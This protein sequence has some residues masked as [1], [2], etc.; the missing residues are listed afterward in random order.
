MRLATT[1]HHLWF[2]PVCLWAVHPSLPNSYFSMNVYYLACFLTLTL[3]FVGR[4]S[5]P[6]EIIVQVKGKGDEVKSKSVYMNINLSWELWKDIHAKFLDNVYKVLPK[7]L[8][9]IVV[10]LFGCLFNIV[11]FNL[12]GIIERI[13]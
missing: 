13:F 7:P 10:S 4:I 6:K 1:F 9:I 3:T 2:L 11:G 12:F 8:L 5:S